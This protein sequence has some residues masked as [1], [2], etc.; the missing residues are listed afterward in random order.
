MT[1]DQA[2][3]PIYQIKDQYLTGE[4]DSLFS[5]EVW[6]QLWLQLLRHLVEDYIIRN[7]IIKPSFP[8]GYLTFFLNNSRL[9]VL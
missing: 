8:A 4:T 6:D 5:S 9:S 1:T 7:I 3:I 2:T